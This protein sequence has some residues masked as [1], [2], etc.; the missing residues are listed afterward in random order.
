MSDDPSQSPP[1]H[2]E[3]NPQVNPYVTSEYPLLAFFKF[4]ETDGKNG[5]YI[6][7]LDKVMPSFLEV[8]N[9]LI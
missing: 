8:G 4:E 7:D 1:C 9:I 6:K 2:R 5:G 3:S